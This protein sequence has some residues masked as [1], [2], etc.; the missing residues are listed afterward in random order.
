MKLRD[1]IIDCIN[2]HKTERKPLIIPEWAGATIYLYRLSGRDK[3]RWETLCTADLRAG[4]SHHRG[5]FVCMVLRD[6]AGEKIFSEED[7][8]I[9]EAEHG[10]I[11]E[12]IM[13]AS[14]AYN[15]L[16]PADIEELRAALGEAVVEAKDS[17]KN[18]DAILTADSTLDSPRS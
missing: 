4:E 13:T 16:M 1:H 12:R 14:A 7:Y 2:Q 8:S 17:G 9:V 15:D 11:L 6:E 10:A 3:D 5:R 18:S